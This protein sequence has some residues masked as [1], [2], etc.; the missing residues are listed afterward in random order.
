MVCGAFGVSVRLG[1]CASAAAASPAG[2]P[3]CFG[4]R[5]RWRLRL[6]RLCP[7][8]RPRGFWAV[9]Q[10]MGADFAMVLDF[11]AVFDGGCSLSAQPTWGN[12]GVLWRF[13][14]VRPAKPSR[15]CEWGLLGLKAAHLGVCFGLVGSG[16]KHC[17]CQAAYVDAPSANRGA[18]VPGT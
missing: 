18:G 5:P 7:R 2:A 8:S 12:A 11:C 9:S 13:G 1:M 10:E 4:L 15:S 17:D 3:R 14:P 16:R 6:V